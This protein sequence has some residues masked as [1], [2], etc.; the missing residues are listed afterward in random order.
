[1]FPILTTCRHRTSRRDA[2]LTEG[3]PNPSLCCNCAG[4]SSGCRHHETVLAELFRILARISVARHTRI[5]RNSRSDQREHRRDQRRIRSRHAHLGKTRRTLSRSHRGL[6]RQGSKAQRDH[7]APSGRARGRTGTR[8][9]ATDERPA[10]TATRHPRR[11]EGQ[12]RH[13]RPAHDGRIFH[14]AGL[15]PPGRCFCRQEAARRGRHHPRQAQH[16]RVR[17]RRHDELPDRTDA[18]PT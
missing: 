15:D 4:E 16:E 8:R 6:R 11:S 12:L 13:I 9:G 1:M 10:L 14:A 2:P 17:L 7:R 5:G 18:E 3:Y